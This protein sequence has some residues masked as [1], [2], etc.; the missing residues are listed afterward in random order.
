MISKCIIILSLPLQKLLFILKYEAYVAS[1]FKIILVNKIKITRTL[2]RTLFSLL[3]LYL[4]ENLQ[5]KF[6]ISLYVKRRKKTNNFNSINNKF[7]NSI[8]SRY[9]F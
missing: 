5:N 8:V 9:I 7:N 2:L 3:L 6:K 1:Y 4:I